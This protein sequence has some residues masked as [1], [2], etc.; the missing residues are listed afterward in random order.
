MNNHQVLKK[1]YQIINALGKGG[2][3][4]TYLALDQE[5]HQQCV[6]K[7]LLFKQIDD[8]KSIEL[9]EREAKILKNL[10]HPQIPDYIDFFT[11]SGKNR[12]NRKNFRNRRYFRVNRRIRL[13]VSQRPP[14]IS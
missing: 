10:N 3:G 14:P 12:R 9:F 2:F 4:I 1:R 6:V 7:C 8:W 13:D 5:T 11:F